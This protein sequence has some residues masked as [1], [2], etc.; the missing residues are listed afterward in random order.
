MVRTIGD[1]EVYY[2]E[3][4]HDSDAHIP[5]PEIQRVAFPLYK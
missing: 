3:E 2:S 1:E 4:M 5:C